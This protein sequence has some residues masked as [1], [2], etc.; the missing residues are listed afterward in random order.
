[1]VVQLDVDTQ[2]DKSDIF[3]FGSSSLPPLEFATNEAIQRTELFEYALSLGCDSVSLPRFQIFKFIYA[4]RLAESGLCAQAFQYCEV[5]SKVL[6]ASVSRQPLTLISQLIE[7]STKMRHFDQQLKDIPDLELSSEPEWLINLRRLHRQI[8]EELNSPS[9]KK[10]DTNCLPL[11]KKDPQGTS[12]K[13]TTTAS[14]KVSL[15][16]TKMPSQEEVLPKVCLVPP[17]PQDILKNRA[18]PKSSQAPDP[19][20]FGL[21]NKA[22][23]L[24]TSPMSQ[25]P[26]HHADSNLSPVEEPVQALKPQTVPEPH[27]HILPSTAALLPERLVHTDDVQHLSEHQP[28][29]V[30]ESTPT[31]ALPLP[32]PLSLHP[33]IVQSQFTEDLHSQSLKAD[34]AATQFP[35]EP[36]TLSA[37]TL[38][39]ST[40]VATESESLSQETG[41]GWFSWLFG[42]KKEVNLPADTGKSLVWDE[43][44]QIWVDPN[45]ENKKNKSALEYSKGITKVTTASTGDFGGPTAGLL[46]TMPALRPGPKSGYMAPLNPVLMSNNPGIQL[47]ASTGISS[48]E[49]QMVRPANTYLVDNAVSGQSGYMRWT[50]NSQPATHSQTAED[51]LQ[52]I[53]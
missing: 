2:S 53:M 33:T 3:L 50:Q 38:P 1:M 6:L 52:E 41:G 12:P 37:A 34:P 18:L 22:V 42:K 19:G 21:G 30:K 35:M 29:E 46:N 8:I 4:C 31:L 13:K 48:S 11:L 25:R 39:S 26:P 23:A 14:Y 10:Q 16:T 28:N 49:A 40:S 17:A 7:L 20:C 24:S 27:L 9:S 32:A 51:I 45:E 44:L 36:H 43:N 15:L 5:I 47:Y